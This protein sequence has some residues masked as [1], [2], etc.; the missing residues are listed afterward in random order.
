MKENNSN[1]EIT[2]SITNQ[3]WK[4]NDTLKG[5]LSSEDFDVLLLILS[6][7]KDG[8]INQSI[9]DSEYDD[10]SHSDL[11]SNLS[12]LLSNSE[13]YSNLFNVYS[14]NLQALPDLTI[15]QFLQ[16]TFQIEKK[17]LGEHF[18]AVFDNLLYKYSAASGKKSGEFILPKEISHFIM[19]LAT[20]APDAKVYN[21]F[22][23]LASFGI[24]LQPDQLYVAEELKYKTWA[25]GTLRLMAHNL[26]YSEYKNEDSI[27]RWKHFQFDLIVAYPPFNVKL[28]NYY[29]DGNNNSIEEVVINNSFNQLSENGQLICVLPLAFLFKE[30]KERKFREKIIDDG[31]IDTIISLPP[32]LLKNTG[33][34]FCIVVFQKK[35]N[36]EG[37]RF[38]EANEF[39]GFNST[40]K[41]KVFDS[42]SLLKAIEANDRKSVKF[43][44]LEIIKE[45]DFNLSVS[46]YFIDNN[47][48]NI[49]IK[50][51][52][53]ILT[54]S[55]V[56]KEELGKLIKTKDLKDN[57]ID[58]TLDAHS[59]ESV[60]I[61][62]IGIRKISQDCILVALKWKTLKPTFFKYEGEP[63]YIPNE[64]IALEVDPKIAKI[65]YFINELQAGYLTAQANKLRIGG[66]IPSL[67]MEDFYEMQIKVPT[68]EE[69]N[70]IYLSTAKEYIDTL[71]SES[72]NEFKA[73]RINT[74]DENSFLR[75]QIAG[76]LKSARGSFKFIKKIL[77]EKL[78]TRAP[79]LFELKAD[80]KLD[81]T[82]RS[83][84]NDLERD[85]I[86]INKSINRAGDKI[87][88]MD[89]HIENF[90]LL[91][92]IKEYKQSLE[93]RSTNFYEVVLNLDEDAIA[94]YGISAIHIEGDKDLLRKMLDNI[95]ENAEKHAFSYGIN[96]AKQNKIEIYLMYDFE[97]FNVQMDVSNT[98]KPLPENM[99]YE[100]YVRKGSTSGPAA[101][102][103]TGGWFIYEVMKIHKGEFGFTDETARG[104]LGGEFVTSIEL[105]FPIIPAI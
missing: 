64:I 101:G 80:N 104:G 44:A 41:E 22:A 57:I 99:T 7:Y 19:Q 77:E 28:P 84:L 32:G 81:S 18:S 1:I 45:N 2:S 82:L 36:R 25:L 67:K 6:A 100:S 92:F 79:D 70:K 102:D 37:I 14:R 10:F 17:L 103:G 11:K 83:Y 48:S 87:E 9:Y 73:N 20:I 40:N 27:E 35:S 49:L 93:S 88:L 26:N 69:Q 72:E 3:I 95:I 54:G 50:D 66:I 89:L 59:I 46:R 39:I 21:P 91:D 90:D 8:L 43:V 94:E 97:N 42:I 85:L 52:V 74:E 38:I 34:A 65:N 12:E 29:I 56:E 13:K 62:K 33:I 68:V 105:T 30:G 24:Y 47:L 76:S 96:T 86:S 23:G 55:K 75:H 4:I 63:I 78:I 71:N 15:A 61:P 58:Y 53:T 16:Y 98:G 60:A 5:Y 31:F 51:V